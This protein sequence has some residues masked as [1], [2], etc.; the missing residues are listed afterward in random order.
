MSLHILRKRIIIRL[1]KW[2][3]QEAEDCLWASLFLA[4]I[5]L[6]Q[7]GAKF[8]CGVMVADGGLQRACRTVEG[9]LQSA[10]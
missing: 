1:R 4:G 2:C 9:Y 7:G 8:P 6:A 10:P 3:D 5:L